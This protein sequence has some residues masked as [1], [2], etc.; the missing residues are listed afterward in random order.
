MPGAGT[1]TETVCCR[2]CG[3]SNVAA[4][5]TI[6]GKLHMRCRNCQ[7]IWVHAET[8]DRDREAAAY[9]VDNNVFITNGNNNYYFDD[10]NLL[11]A[12]SKL[13]W[14]MQYAPAGSRLLDA[15]ANF[16][17][18]LKIAQ[19]VY[20]VLGFDI[21]PMAVAWSQKHLG[22]PNRVGSIYALD[23]DF[24]PAF[25]LI[26]CWD[27]IEHLQEPEEAL[28]E[29]HKALKP[30]G[31]LFL[32][33]PDAGSVVARLLGRRWHYLDPTQHLTLFNRSNLARLL[34]STGYK[35][36]GI[37]AVGHYYRVRYIVDRLTY[38]Y[39]K[40][41]VHPTRQENVLVR[42]V[43]ER[44]LKICLGDVMAIVARRV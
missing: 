15:G 3:T 4:W 27:V 2:I 7:L 36:L 41:V 9:R 22:V 8:V 39:K 25:D 31:Y 35:V 44:R 21:S 6:R 17:H 29:L 11:S 16:G 43:L 37:R 34:K 40:R 33:T 38:L 30:E 19:R 32:S 5:A 13:K 12:E 10:S 26:T 28:R 1:I 23:E 20:N 14:I 24:S 42:F 18:F